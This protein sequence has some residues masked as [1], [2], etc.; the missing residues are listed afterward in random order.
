MNELWKWL[1]QFDVI[2]GVILCIAVIVS[3]WYDLKAEVKDVKATQVQYQSDLMQHRE[4]EAARW[5]AQR[6]RD[7][8]QDA[9]VHDHEVE[10]HDLW[11]HHI[12]PTPKR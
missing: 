10:I 3:S 1:T 4:N 2:K 5:E 6:L 11:R 8:K 9:Q 12:A 7:E